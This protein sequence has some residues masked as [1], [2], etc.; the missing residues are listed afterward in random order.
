MKQY[1]ALLFGAYVCGLLLVVVGSIAAS[2]SWTHCYVQRCLPQASG[3]YFRKLNTVPFTQLILSWNINRPAKGYYRFWGRLHDAKRRRWLEWHRLMEWGCDRQRSFFHKGVA[4]VNYYVRL[5]TMHREADGFEIYLEPCD[6]SSFEEAMLAV[7][8]SHTGRFLPEEVEQY[9]TLP[10]IAIAD[11][12]KLSQMVLSHP[13]RER[14]CSPTSMMMVG[15]YLGK[16]AIDEQFIDGVYD[17]GL[18]VFGSW[19]FNCAHLYT[20]L[21]SSYHCLVRRLH[22]FQSLYN[23]VQQGIPVPVSIR[24]GLTGAPQAYPNGHFVVV[25]GYDAATKRVLCHDPAVLPAPDLEKAEDICKAYDLAEFILAWER[26]MRL[27]YYIQPKTV[28]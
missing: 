11:V 2:N 8:V 16:D 20:A 10:S 21:Q 1:R 13:E 22:S 3:A 19:A 18:G 27:A 9:A 17:H 25:V 14:V 23:V 6:D 26:S 15:T 5:E 24:G 4:S 7:T 28:V 12:P